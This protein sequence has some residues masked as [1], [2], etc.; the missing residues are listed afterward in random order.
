MGRG[1]GGGYDTESQ[2][3]RKLTARRYNRRLAGVPQGGQFAPKTSQE[4]N[5]DLTDPAGQRVPSAEGPVDR[6]GL[7]AATFA[8]RHELW[9]YIEHPDIA[10]R[11]A[12]TTNVRLD[13][14]QLEALMN[15]QR[16]PVIVR[17]AAARLLR[18]GVAERA[19]C[20]PAPE[21]RQV[22]LDGWDLPDELRAELLADGEVILARLVL[23]G[24]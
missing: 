14:Y 16:Q 21:V 8:S 6:A 7:P 18:A 1:G 11:I 17:R 23:C 12:A 15:C 20:D 24:C 10:E 5:V 13:N 19:A 2:P 4:A 22:A 3:D 9:G